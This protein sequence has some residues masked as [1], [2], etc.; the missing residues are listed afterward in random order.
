[1]KIEFEE[2]LRRPKDPVQA[3]KLSSECGVQLR[4]EMPLATKWKHYE[5]EE[6][7][8]V[9]PEIL[10]PLSVSVPNML[11]SSPCG[12]IYCCHTMII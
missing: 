4:N 3:A 11:Y 9:I 1:M 5:K 6:M 12:S 10:H 8:H 2:G 7:K